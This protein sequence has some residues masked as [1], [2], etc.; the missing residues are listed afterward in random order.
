MGQSKSS[1]LSRESQGMTYCVGILFKEGIVLAFDSTMRSNLSVGMP[2]DLVC[3]E[4]DSLETPMRPRFDEADAYFI[5]LRA[6]WSEGV[7]R[8][9]G[10]L[11]ELER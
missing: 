2:I 10:E 5:A 8:V 7:R 1:L 3:Y 4:R 6:D 11:P 9:F